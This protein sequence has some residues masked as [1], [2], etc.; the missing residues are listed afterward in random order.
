MASR[1]TKWGVRAALVPVIAAGYVTLAG[2]T[3]YCPNCANIMDTVLGRAGTPI[4]PGASKGSI[5]ELSVYGLNGESVSLSRFV[6]KPTVIDV[7][8]TWCPPCRTQRKVIHGLDV[9]FLE[10]F[11]MVS[12]STDTNPGIVTSYLEKNP[13]NMTDL[14]STSE[15]LKAFGGVSAIP[16]LVFVDSTGQIRDVSTGVH[17]ASELKRRVQGLAQA[18]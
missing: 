16:T 9:E 17:S 6:G 3:G 12:L 4:Q 2:L 1:L 15:A 7:W 14:M 8:A 5:K 11:N 18:R 13:S 10:T